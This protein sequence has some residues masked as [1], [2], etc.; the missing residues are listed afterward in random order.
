MAW[1]AQTSAS[2]SHGRGQKRGTDHRTIMRPAATGTMT[3]RRTRSPDARNELA[4]RVL[5]VGKYVYD[6]VN[7]S[8]GLPIID[9]FFHELRRYG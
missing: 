5:A 4:S 8:G 3:T 1:A 7:R 9:D 6:E 2:P